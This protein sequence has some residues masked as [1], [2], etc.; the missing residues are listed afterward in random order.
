MPLKIRPYEPRDFAALY[1]LDQSCF[2]PGISYSKWVL[3]YYLCLPGVDCQ[4][5]LDGKFIVGFVLGES[6]PPLGH[7]ITLDV[8]ESHRRSGVGS[9]LL[10]ELEKNF[11]F[12]GVKSVLLET[13]VDNESGIAFWKRHG[14]CTEAVLKRYYLQKIDAY[15][16]RKKLPAHDGGKL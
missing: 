14:Y 9:L 7:I 12:R 11:A 10:E 1:K 15:E 3:H 5:A 13:A 4:V 8:A 6:N 16:M 2:V